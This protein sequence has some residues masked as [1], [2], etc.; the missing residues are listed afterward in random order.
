MKKIYVLDTNVLLQDPES[1]HNFEDNEVVL[2]DTVIEE[3]DRLKGRN[4]ELGYNSRKCIREIEMLRKSGD[5]LAGVPMKDG[6]IFRIETDCKDVEMPEDWDLGKADNNVIRIAK[7]LS[8]KHSDKKVILVSKDA[9]VR[10]KA[11]TVGVLS[12]DYDTEV[13]DDED[14]IYNGRCLIEVEYDLISNFYSTHNIEV[15]DEFVKKNKL[16]ENEYVTLACGSATALGRYTKNHI[17]GLKY[18]KATPCDITLLNSGQKFAAEALLA[19]AEEVPLVI[20]KGPAG[21]AK[22]FLTLACGLEQVMEPQKAKNKKKLSSYRKILL[23]RA[24]VAF[25]NDLGALPGDEIDKVSPL[26]RGCLDNIELLLDKESVKTGGSD[27]EYELRDKVNEVFDR[28]WVS[29]EALG[30]LRGR[31]ITNQYVLID[32]AQNT[33]PNQMLGILTRAGEGTKIVICGDLDQIDNTKLDRHTNGL[34][35]ALKTMAGSELCHIVGFSEKEA[36]RSPLAKEAAKR[37]VL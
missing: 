16:K 29:I 18:E 14:L 22:T 9:I 15:S 27:A 23:S 28:G 5:I 37:M 1:I 30:Y 20:L 25:D 19:P 6:G 34:A 13:V 31:S 11:T 32:E 12:E 36:T 17:V 7:G 26:L 2:P 35:F 21:T 24:N 33:S 3:L 8:E 10:I 4:G